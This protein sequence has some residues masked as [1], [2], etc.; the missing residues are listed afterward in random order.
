MNIEIEQ[1][2]EALAIL[3]DQ[4]SL[5][6][7]GIRM[8]M[9]KNSLKRTLHGLFPKIKS[10]SFTSKGSMNS[11]QAVLLLYLRLPRVVAPHSRHES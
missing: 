5:E 2:E 9:Q 6:K 7:H 8:A 11:A 1:V 10:N 4:Y 3:E